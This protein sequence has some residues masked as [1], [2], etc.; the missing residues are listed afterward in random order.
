MKYTQPYGITDPDAPYIN[1]DPSIG[2]AGSIPPA[3]AIEAPQ[4]ELDNFIVKSGIVPD[5]NNNMQL[6][7][8]FQTSGLIYGID[9][10]TANGI[11]I[12]LTQAPLDLR[13][14]MI[15]R[16]LVKANNTGPTTMVVNNLGPK[17]V[18]DRATGAALAPDTIIAQ[19]FCEFLYGHGVWILM[20]VYAS[21]G[22][23]GGDISIQAQNIL[24][25]YLTVRNAGGCIVPGSRVVIPLVPWA[26]PV[27]DPKITVGFN[28]GTGSFTVPVGYDGLWL[29]ESYTN[30]LI[31]DITGYTTPEYSG[32]RFYVNGTQQVMAASYS[33][34]GGVIHNNTMMFWNAVAG[35]SLQLKVLSDNPGITLTNFY[36]T[37]IRLGRS[38]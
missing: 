16:V 6:V 35:N 8:A 28:P 5:P 15:V 32:T 29:F 38:T 27:G 26:A 4:R 21:G 37:A 1:G 22:G 9:T 13:D 19:S 11:I 30:S 36:F 2:R 23:G 17:Q 10:G 33:G 18:V 24:Y 34:N 12:T 25:P 20:S 14:G 3:M 31:T 7:S